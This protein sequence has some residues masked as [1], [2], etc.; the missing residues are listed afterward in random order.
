MKYDKEI[1]YQRIFDNFDKEKD[2]A[3]CFSIVRDVFRLHYKEIM[4]TK[5]FISWASN[6][7]DEIMKSKYDPIFNV[8]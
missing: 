4:D 6:N 7:F 3:L 8:R 5:A 2:I 1:Y